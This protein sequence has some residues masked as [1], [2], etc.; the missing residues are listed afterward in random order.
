M[1]FERR[2]KRPVK[3]TDDT[4]P[5]QMTY[6]D[7]FIGSNSGKS[8]DKP[9]DG[10]RLTETAYGPSITVNLRLLAPDNYVRPS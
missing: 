5:M 10:R 4:S 6:G 1:N 9:F 2:H 8:F 3:L 7:N